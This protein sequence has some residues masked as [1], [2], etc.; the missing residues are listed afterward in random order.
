MSVCAFVRA[1]L[2][3]SPLACAMRFAFANRAKVVECENC[4]GDLARPPEADACQFAHLLGPICRARLWRARCDLRSQTAPGV[5]NAKTAL[6]ILFA[7]EGRSRLRA[8]RGVSA[9]RKRFTSA[10][11]PQFCVYTPAPVRKLPSS[12]RS[13]RPPCSLRTPIGYCGLRMQTTAC[14][15]VAGTTDPANSAQTAQQPALRA[16]SPT[17]EKK[18]CWVYSS[19]KMKRI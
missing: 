1:D 13:G 4:N 10:A 7:P 5:W 15:P 16:D 14:P 6:P 19:S 12:P 18:F 2:P 9:T 8:K 17:C 3:R 11:C